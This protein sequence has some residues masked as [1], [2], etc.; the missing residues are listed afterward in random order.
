MR[1]RKKKKKMSGAIGLNESDSSYLHENANS[2]IVALSGENGRVSSVVNPGG[3]KPTVTTSAIFKKKAKE[4][5]LGTQVIS[6]NLACVLLS[7]VVF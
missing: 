1:V 2:T 5:C 3:K 7:M 4:L 6:L